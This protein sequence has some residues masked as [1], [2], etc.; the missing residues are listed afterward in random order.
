MYVLCHELRP[1]GKGATFPT[2][3][4][5]TTAAA[6]LLVAQILLF[7]RSGTD[8]TVSELPADPSVTL[9]EDQDL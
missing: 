4:M 6:G 3:C 5:A 1:R 2:R 7:E 8:S 9:R